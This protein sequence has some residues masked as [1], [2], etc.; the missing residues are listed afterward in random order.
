MKIRLDWRKSAQENAAAYYTL[1]K[2]MASKEAGAKKA[3]L[4]T[5]SEM[6]KAALEGKKAA[7]Q[8]AAESVPTMKRKKEWFEKYRWFYTSSGKLVVAGRD[9]KQNDMLVSK[10]MA[11]DDLFFHADIQGAPATILV[12]GKASRSETGKPEGGSPQEKLETAQFAASHSSAW[13]VGAAAVDVYAVKKSQLSKH[14]QG[15][16]VGAGGFAIA[17]EREWFRATALGL[18]IGMESHA[19]SQGKD[20]EDGTKLVV[21][22]PLCHPDA[23]K[24]K[25]AAGIGNYEKGQATKIIAK[26][27]GANPDEILLALPSGKFSLKERK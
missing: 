14:A 8:A 12:G 1:S 26:A 9:A 11:E 17:G 23:A 3:M 15:G 21:C 18:A 5:E 24:M 16:F 22:L 4:E 25:F 19:L 20:A 27:L 13:K 2:E 6:G 7:M 10:V